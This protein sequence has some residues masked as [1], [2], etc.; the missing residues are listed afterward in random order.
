MDDPDSWQNVRMWLSEIDR[1]GP[2]GAITFLVG[3]KSD[4]PRS[5]DEEKVEALVR[6]HVRLMYAECSSKSGEGVDE[7]FEKVTEAVV[8]HGRETNI[9]FGRDV[10]K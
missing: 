6:E 10:P 3:T 1:Y 5:V 8:K 7:L 9:F 4:L 2:E